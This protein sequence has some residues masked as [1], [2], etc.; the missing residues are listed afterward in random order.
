M[1]D[2]SGSEAQRGPVSARRGSVPA[3]RLTFRTVWGGPSPQAGF[4]EELARIK[5]HVRTVDFSYDFDL[6][7]TVGGEITPIPSPSG[8]RTPRVFL[9]QRTVTGEIRISDDDVSAASA[10][11]AFLRQTIHTAV[12]ELMSRIA[13]RDSDFDVDAERGKIAF[14][15]DEA[16]TPDTR[17]APDATTPGAERRSR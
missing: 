13:A 5:Q 17:A 6:F 16:A 2:P 7:L 1:T 11:I 15:D 14:L 12:A 10:P 4:I 9:S 3:G 8:L